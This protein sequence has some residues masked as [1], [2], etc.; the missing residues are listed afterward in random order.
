MLEHVFIS[1]MG[2]VNQL[3]AANVI[4]EHA[5]SAVGMINSVSDVTIG[6]FMALATGGTI[7]VAQLY[8]KGD[9][10]RAKRAGAQAITLSIIVSIIVFVGF[11]AFRMPIINGLLGD[12]EESVFRAGLDFFTVV[13]PS[14]PMLA[15]MQAAFGI[16]R[17]S[18]N[19]KTPMQITLI[20]NVV[21]VL[22]G[23][24]LI[25]SWEISLFGIHIISPSF[26]ILGAGLALTLSRLSG[27]VL[28]L[29]YIFMKSTTIRF[30]SIKDFMPSLTMQ[31]D[32]LGIGI[33]T[34]VESSMF[35]VGR[36]I[37]QIFIVGMGTSALFANNVSG[38]IFGFMG[39]PGFA[40]SQGVMIMIGQMV[41]R[42]DYGDIKKTAL[43]TT[44]VGSAMFAVICLALFPFTGFIARAFNASPESAAQLIPL[45]R[46]MFI[47]T[48]LFWSTGFVTPAAL[49][50]MGDVKY[51]MYVGLATMWGLRIILGYVLGVH[52]GLGV[53]GIWYA[54]VLDWVVRTV[55]FVQRV[56]KGK[57]MKN[58]PQL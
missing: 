23:F 44:A 13:I 37:T 58:L 9:L 35:Q 53:M 26:G 17:G 40:F 19:T 45:L 4:G 21:N 12:A 49:R 34:G 10:G 55:L 8:G 43:F 46:F 30:D 5:V 39:I 28:I 20:M 36:L 3:M 52:F 57:W 51:T 25:F 47:M 1:V 56:V 24:I 48:P 33:P 38:T 15:I 32:I 7:V 11:S 31:K 41:G 29:L 50:A 42:G 22:L 6:V 14:F 2:I 54:M 18:G 16:I 27:M